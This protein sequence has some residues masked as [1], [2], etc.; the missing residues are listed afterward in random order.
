MMSTEVLNN[1]KCTETYPGGS[2]QPTVTN[3][4]WDQTELVYVVRSGGL[5]GRSL[6][7]NLQRTTLL[8]NHPY[9]GTRELCA[10]YMLMH[11]MSIFQLHIPYK[12]NYPYKYSINIIFY[13]N[14][15][16]INIPYK[17]QIGFLSNNRTAD[18]ALTLRNLID[19]YVHGYQSISMLC[20]LQKSLRVGMTWWTSVQ[21]ITI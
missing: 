10:K 18:H 17:C 21:A 5:W 11:E 3:N 16:H 4:Y 2:M 12:Y 6:S 13:I 20:W 14:I 15:F 7:G 19:K 8:S 9:Q 1:L